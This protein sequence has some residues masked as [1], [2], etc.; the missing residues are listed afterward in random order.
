MLRALESLPGRH[1]FDE[2]MLTVTK[3]MSPQG[4][5]ELQEKIKAHLK[6]RAEAGA[7]DL[8]EAEALPVLVG[9]SLFRSPMKQ[10]PQDE[11]GLVA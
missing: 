11:A 5:D 1:A 7:A 2:W 8:G 4:F 6:E 9:G 3:D 10:Q